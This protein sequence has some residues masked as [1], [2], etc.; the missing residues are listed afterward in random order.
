MIEVDHDQLKWLIKHCYKS[1][2]SLMVFGPVGIGKSWV[3]K[4]ATKE[5]AEEFDLQYAENVPDEDCDPEKT[6]RL[7]DIRLAGCGDPSDVR[8][9]I[10]LDKETRKGYWA[11]PQLFPHKGKGIIYFDE[12]NLAFPSVQYAVYEAIHPMDRRLGAY[13]IPEGFVTMAAGNRMKDRTGVFHMQDAFRTRFSIV[14]LAIPAIDPSNPNMGWA[15]WAIEN[16]IDSRIISYL[17]SSPSSLY[18]E[19]E[20]ATEDPLPRP[21]TWH[22]AS[23]SIRDIPNDSEHLELCMA[24]DVGEVEA[25]KF[26]AF[27]NLKRQIDIEGIINTPIKV[28][29]IMDSK[30]TDLKFACIDSI[31]NYYITSDKQDHRLD[32]VLEIA[33]HLQPEFAVLLFRYCSSSDRSDFILKVNDNAIW[34]DKLQKELKD[35]I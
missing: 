15:K 31:Y 25:Y 22:F 32:K 26:I 34:K 35:F 33:T 14:N 11:V 13:K 3:Q 17:M 16:N 4:Q 30:E 5:L 27:I 20:K 12:V 10:G 28:K 1:S 2:Q 29:D 7:V 6:F 8:G 23:N 18:V 24:K 19:L 9:I 21:R